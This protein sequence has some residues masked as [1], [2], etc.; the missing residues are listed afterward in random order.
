MDVRRLPFFY[1]WLLVGLGALSY[2]VGYGSRGTFSVFYVALLQEFGWTRAALAGV[3]SLGMAIFALASPLA[4]ILVD[5]L[6]PRLVL[7]VG[8]LL[9]ALGM[10]LSGLA[11]QLWH[12]YLVFGLFA[13]L[14]YCFTGLVPNSAVISNWFVRYRG[15]ALGLAFAGSG[16]GSLILVP[17]T[18]TLISAFTWR[19]AFFV[20]GGIIA[21]LLIPLNALFQRHRP[22]ELGL[23]PDGVAPD[24][25]DHSPLPERPP[26]S[27]APL[28]RPGAGPAGPALATGPAP[29]VTASPPAAPV[30]R[31]AEGALD[32]PTVIDREWAARTWTV[33]AAMKTSQ[34]WILVF[35]RAASAMAINL[36]LSHQVIHV[37]DKGYTKMLAA[38]IFG[39][40]GLV[41]I[42]GIVG[43]GYLSDRW[44]RE[45]T[46]T[47]SWVGS[48]LGPIFLLL[49]RDSSTPWLLYAYS[50][51]F[52]LGLGSRGSL[53]SAIS[54]DLFQG[55][56]F[57]HIYGYLTMATGAGAAIGP[58]LGGYLYDRLGSYDLAFA[59][60]AAT[61]LACCGGIWVVGA[62]KIRRVGGAVRGRPA[63]GQIR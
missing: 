28:G 5:R 19:V 24:R 45:S 42:V 11:S 41:S 29:G 2:A 18:Q 59:G 15:T 9:L 8:A 31:A 44:G 1:G 14:G 51:F 57:G 52:G 34:F 26:V 63:G 37:V 36:V 6:G 10:A 30:G 16:L 23:Y 58:W 40:S 55:R 39:L 43:L 12:L 22:Q 13:S 21:V 38:S 25:L 27:Q 60:C 4:G 20:L 35:I 32:D 54:A 61:L 7:P 49:V 33:L 46:L 48:G 50:L 17:L 62:H 56:H 47:V 3:Y 53:I